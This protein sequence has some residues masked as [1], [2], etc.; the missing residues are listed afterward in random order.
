MRLVLAAA[1]LFSSLIAQTP[2]VS[3]SGENMRLKAWSVSGGG[4]VYTLT[5]QMDDDNGDA[6]LPT[7]FRRWW[8]CEVGNLT[9]GTVLNVRVTN[10]GYSDV[11]LPV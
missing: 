2:S 6:S 11:I 5:L 10:A 4:G 8:H 1:A 9:P 7:S 3:A